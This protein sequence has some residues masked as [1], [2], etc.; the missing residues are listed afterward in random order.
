MDPHLCRICGLAVAAFGVGIDLGFNV[1]LFLSLSL[2]L[3]L[4]PKFMRFMLF[5]APEGSMAIIDTSLDSTSS[6]LLWH[7]I[8]IQAQGESDSLP[9][10]TVGSIC[11]SSSITSG[12]GIGRCPRL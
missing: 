9:A 4:S 1:T 7:L 3:I 11:S 8:H 6:C 5:C 10:V 12:H 2:L